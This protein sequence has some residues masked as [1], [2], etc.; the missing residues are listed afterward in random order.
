V[1]QPKS[2]WVERFERLAQREGGFAYPWRSRVVQPHGED[3][4]TQLVLEHL[5]P[6][7]DVIEAGCGHGSDALE[8][9]P[10][11]RSYLG[12]DA[13]EPFI[14]TCRQRAAA[15]GIDNAQ[16]VVA[17]S[18]PKRGGRMPAPER[19]ADLVITRRGPTNPLLDARRVCR[20][21]GSVI[22]LYFVAP[23][24]PEW[25]A[26]LPEDIRLAHH[27]PADLL[28]PKVHDYAAR[29]GLRL[30]ASWAFDVPELFDDPQEL[31]KH[32]VWNRELAFDE[33]RALRAIEAIF[34]QHAERGCVAVRHR[35]FLY[36][37]VVDG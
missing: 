18:S 14:R 27:E 9:A 35:R 4:Y 1:A 8:L 15:A 34:A 3:A 29:G 12:Y 13:V 36:Q 23:P 25:N 6:E 32:I 2:E 11:V 16:F 26:A 21:G 28:A 24:L 17:N 31:L 37:A 30:R 10:R 33:R 19:S 7:L 5:R 22:G 20:P